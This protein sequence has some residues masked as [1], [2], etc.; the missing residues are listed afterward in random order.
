MVTFSGGIACSYYQADRSAGICQIGT[1]DK[2]EKEKQLIERKVEQ[3]LERIVNADSPILI[4]TYER[5]IKQLE[6]Q[7]I[8]TEDKIRNC[9]TIYDNFEKINRTAVE[10]LANPYA[11]WV[12]ADM[13]GER[14][15]LKA[16]FSRPISYHRTHG[17]RTAALS[18]PFS[19]LRGFSDTN[20]VLVEATGIEPATS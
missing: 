8:I 14:L 13:S 2:I 4:N 19:V 20:S 3:F 16:T 17:Y 1:L 11:H 12:S 10:F 18:M 7:R 15:V 6:E 9:G 5:Q